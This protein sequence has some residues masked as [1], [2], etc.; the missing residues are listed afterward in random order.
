MNIK[1]VACLQHTELFFLLSFCF[2]STDK[3]LIHCCDGVSHSL[4][5][6]LAYLTIHRDTMV[7][8]SIDCIIKVWHF[9]VQLMSLDAEHVEQKNNSYRATRQQSATKNTELRLFHNY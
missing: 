4:T 9:L 6:F 7:K 8:E 3:V 1:Y 5:L 2:I